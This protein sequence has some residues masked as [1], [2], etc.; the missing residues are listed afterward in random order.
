VATQPVEENEGS[1]SDEEEE[2]WTNPEVGKRFE[3][4]GRTLLPALIRDNP[5]L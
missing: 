5:Q 4:K 3:A 2:K 1:D